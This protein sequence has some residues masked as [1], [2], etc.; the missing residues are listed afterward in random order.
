[1]PRSHANAHSLF[2]M[3]LRAPLEEESSLSIECYSGLPIFLHIKLLEIT[4]DYNPTNH[5]F[6]LFI[7]SFYIHSFVGPSSLSS[8]SYIVTYLCHILLHMYPAY[9]DS[10]Y[11]SFKIITKYTL[12]H[13]S[14]VLSASFT[15]LLLT[16]YLPEGGCGV[17]FSYLIH[18]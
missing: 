14:G 11:R 18:L 7:L 9:C 13:Y 16:T 5:T 15:V 4:S 12:D 2:Q 17:D 8:L 1:M 6:F 10:T 3:S